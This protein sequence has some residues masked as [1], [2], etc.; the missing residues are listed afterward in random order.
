MKIRIDHGL[1]IVDRG[2]KP[3][4]ET[5]KTVVKSVALQGLDYIGIRPKMLVKTGDNI[6]QGQTLFVDRKRPEIRFVAP[7][8]GTVTSI[9]YA[10]KRMLDVLTIHLKGDEATSFNVP[11]SFNRKNIQE[12]LLN[13]GMW[14]A[15]LTRP[16]G[17]IP[18]PFSV[19]A[20]IFVTAMDT[21]PLAPDVASVILE[22]FELFQSGLELIEYL[23]DGTVFICHAPNLDLSKTENSRIK[24]VEF[25]GRHPAG[26][27]GTH[28]NRLYRAS[29]KRTV[30][31]IGYQD[32]IALGGLLVTNKYW[33]K[34]TIAIA[35]S[36]IK[37]PFLTHTRVGANISD[38]LTDKLQESNLQVFSGSL[39]SGHRAKFLGR[40]HTRISVIK[41][42]LNAP[43]WQFLKHILQPLPKN[44]SGSIIPISALE[45]ALA[46]D[47][48]PV[49]LIRSL[50]IG[51]AHSAKRL[52]C[53]ELIEEDVALL[54]YICASKN[55]YGILLREILDELEMKGA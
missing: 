51:D 1:D 11:N 26:L 6:T 48:L 5:E 2:A 44:N 45:G 22:Q 36:G 39:L 9:E 35:G 15:F 7:G 21:G 40:F 32:V 16:F 43:K 41:E 17:K 14:N 25:S 23:T 10:H 38:L 52:G 54:T 50:S 47:I 12:L 55:N 34:R 8:T 24:T 18:D 27:P 19:P 31:H 53:L 13:A 37:N 4:T 49:P 29:E 3:P 20:A 33:A 46:L 30:W 42:T 28:I